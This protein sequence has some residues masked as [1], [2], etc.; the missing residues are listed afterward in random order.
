V[1]RPARDHDDFRLVRVAAFICAMM[2]ILFPAASVAY[3]DVPGSAAAF[4]GTEA[5]LES[6]IFWVAVAMVSGISGAYLVK[7]HYSRKHDILIRQQEEHNALIDEMTS[8]FASCIDMKDSYTNGHSHRVAEYSSLIAEKMGKSKEEVR[9]IYRIALLHDIGKIAIPDKI[10]N[11]PSHLTDDEY[12]L[13]KTHPYRGYVIL[14]EVTIAPELAI[15]AG[16]HHERMD[17]KGY[18]WGK[19]RDEIPEIAQIIAVADTFDA[20]YST[21]PYRKKLDLDIVTAE[22]KRCAGT[23]LNEDIVEILL[24]LIDEGKIGD[25]DT[26]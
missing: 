26:E 24:S 1:K 19:K 16:Y 14:K 25:I 3:A 18:P 20:M 13:M 21:R 9:M 15:G 12:S 8:V 22:L 10:L 6:P 11:K 4:I 5:V 7:G 23:Q 2:S 17:G